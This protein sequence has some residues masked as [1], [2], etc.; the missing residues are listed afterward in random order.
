[1]VALCI[2]LTVLAALQLVDI[3]T[4]ALR[5]QI[6]A[7]FD[8]IAVPDT[9]RTAAERVRHRF[10]ASDTV[11]VVVRADDVFAPNVLARVDALSRAL[12]AIDGVAS[13]DSLT[14]T[15]LPYAESGG[16]RHKRLRADDLTNTQA[17]EQ[18]R[19][20]A[21]ANPLVT[22]QLVA[23]DARAA[24]IVVA[25]APVLEGDRGRDDRAARIEQIADGERSADVAIHVTGGLVVQNALRDAIVR[26]LRWTAP[27]IAVVL[28]SLLA[29]AFGSVRALLVPFVTISIA[30]LWTGATASLV[31]YSLNLVTILVPPLLV[32]MGL[33]YS[34]HVLSD[35]ETLV[36]EGAELDPIER[37]ATLLDNVG[38]PILVTGA[39]TIVALLALLVNEQGQIRDFAVLSA[40]G[41]G[42]LVVLTLLFVP[43]ALGLAGA[44]NFPRLG[45]DARVFERAAIR[46]GRFDRER[47]P[48]IL[49][50]AALAFAIAVALSTRIAVGDTFVGVFAPESH[51][52]SDFAAANTAMGGVT[53][54]DIV[55]EGTADSWT[56]PFLL[57]H[58]DRLTRWLKDQPEVGASVSLVDHVRML[59]RHLGGDEAARVPASR[60]VVRELMFFGESA[61]LQ[62]V[63]DANRSSTR[64]ALRLRV[65]DTA[66]IAGF[67]G[68]LDRQLAVLPSGLTTYLTGDAVRMTQSVAT[69]TRGQLQSV[70]LTLVLV[71]AALSIQFMSLR[72]GLLT[73]IPTILQIALYFGTLGASGISL[74]ATT[75]LVE[76]LVLGLAVDD[77]IHYLARFSAAA[78]RAGSESDAAVAALAAVLRPVTITKGILAVGFLLLVGGE[79]N[80]QR[81]F[82]WMGAFT[83]GCS[84][85]VDVF[86]TPAFVSRLHITTL[87][88]ILRIN[89]G[90]DVRGTIPLFADLTERQ[91]RTFARMANLQSLPAGEA[92]LREGD[93]AGDIYV[94]IDGELR[95]WVERDGGEL[96]LARVGRGTVIGEGGY[97]GRRRNAN[98]EAVSEVRLL[99][100][101]DADQERICRAYP[102]I[103]ARVF[104]ALNRLQAQ[105]HLE[106]LSAGA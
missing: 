53:P 45:H 19:S 62:S 58:L 79:L 102:A 89:L 24:T 82:G 88:D 96:E 6:D 7:S 59:A 85:L 38:G 31:G 43:A 16:L 9:A 70:A 71:V 64:I 90:D 33:A 91:A 44:R 52:R 20:V 28:A 51:V 5:L 69:A 81:M 103:A 72:I 78:R 56:D 68:R 14:A 1:V 77:T 100:F 95:I 54:L 73:S 83:L 4:G 25:L 86:V 36:R 30:L 97:F 27:V 67:I 21:L 101:D 13:V 47:R 32:T 76:C 46:I 3:R 63:V 23:A 8:G 10:R 105:R 80:N 74:N 65:D 35:Y 48:L 106:R 49:A 87:W 37:I 55:I 39:T 42:W 60:D 98:V 61:L 99:G 26:Q 15:A 40:V 17:I 11:F 50:T 66:A 18:L 94:V 104:L 12:A 84:W 92:L 93:P 2:A 75:T 22:G 34:A 57:E 41:V 29:L